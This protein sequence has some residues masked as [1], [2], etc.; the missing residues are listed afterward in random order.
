MTEHEDNAALDF[1]TDDYN[2]FYYT[3]EKQIRKMDDSFILSKLI[4]KYPDFVPSNAENLLKQTFIAITRDSKLI[5]DVVEFCDIT[6]HELFSV[7][8]RNYSFI[9]N[10]SFI[11][12]IQKLVSNRSY[13]KPRRTTP[14]KVNKAARRPDGTRGRGG[15]EK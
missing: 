11:S 3:S 4:E 15:R 1:N 6:V 7:I 10:G 5:N 12:K 2:G 13:A 14:A 8:Y 9:F